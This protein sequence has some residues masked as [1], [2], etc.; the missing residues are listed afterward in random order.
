MEWN[1]IVIYK[2][3]LSSLF[4]VV[5]NLQTLSLLTTF[6]PWLEIAT[7]LY[8]LLISTKEFAATENKRMCSA[9]RLESLNSFMVVIFC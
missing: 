4:L 9:F 6:Q 3:D 8:S 5:L 1:G 7:S 2:S